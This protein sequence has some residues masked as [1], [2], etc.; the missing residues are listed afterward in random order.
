MT[1]RRIPFFNLAASLNPVKAGLD[2]AWNAVY[3]HGG[4]VGGPAVEEFERAF[5]AY[6]EVEHCVGV[7][8]G[9]DA[10]ELAL[11]AL[12]VGPGDEVIVPANTFIATAEAVSNVG[13]V[14]VFADIHPATLL[15]RPIDAESMITPRTVAVIPVHL[16]GQPCDMA[17]FARLAEKAG[18]GLIE[19]AAQAHGSRCD[20]LAPGALSD[21]ATFSFYPGKNL[22]ALGDGGA[23][24]TRNADL[25]E[26]VRSTSAHGRSLEDRYLHDVVGRNSRLDTLQAAFLSVRLDRLDEENTHR[27]RVRAL[28]E[29]WLPASI[30]LVKQEPGRISSNH[31]I[32]AEVDERESFR[33][34]LETMGVQTGLHYPVPCHLQNAYL[35]DGTPAS[36]PVAESAARRIV[37]LPVW[38]QM[39]EDDVAFVCQ[40]I[41][42]LRR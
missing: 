25:A 34:E 27:R 3:E 6:C 13:A 22:G 30:Q 41:S 16:Y 38:G 7:A 10:L 23:L 18:L 28:Y 8:N 36:R 37:S 9:T 29:Q 32:V 12:G 17:G 14:P 11:T 1:E 19:D 35:G 33:R 39:P 42:A 26:K 4:W 40:Q 15:M 31:L 24:V 21:A 5:A 20:G 2:A